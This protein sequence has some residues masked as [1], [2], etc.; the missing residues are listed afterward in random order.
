[1]PGAFAQLALLNSGCDLITIKLDIELDGGLYR[2]RSLL[3][4]VLQSFCIFVRHGA[5][6][7]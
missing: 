1:M 7:V 5:L 2:L 4:N 3:L 6:T